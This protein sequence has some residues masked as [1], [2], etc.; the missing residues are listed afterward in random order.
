M[1]RSH[2]L[3][4]DSPAEAV[5]A[6]CVLFAGFREAVLGHTGPG[7]RVLVGEGPMTDVRTADTLALSAG[8]A[9]VIRL[10]PVLHGNKSGLGSILLGA[11]L[12]V[13]A[14]YAAAALFEAGFV[15][16]AIAVATYGT[17]VATAMILGGAMQMLS[18]QR[19]QSGSPAAR[20]TSY[21]FNGAVN[22]SSPGG[23]V[24]LLIG[25]VITGSVQVSAGLSSDD[26]TLAAPALPASPVRP[27]DELLLDDY[28]RE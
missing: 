23:P 8:S 5:R 28:G 18:P 3:A 26:I 22:V 16:S 15:S 4:V 20:E 12:F 10:A 27:A 2:W 1:E 24:P 7:Y 9:N 17:K 21:I 19:A 25:R 6:L 14:P 13:V 11:V